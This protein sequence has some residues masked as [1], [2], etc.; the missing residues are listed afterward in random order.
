MNKD[1]LIKYVAEHTQLTKTNAA[2]AVNA[3]FESITGS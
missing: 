2:E 3:V 1:D